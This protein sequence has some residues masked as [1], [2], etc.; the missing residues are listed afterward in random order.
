MILTALTQYYQRLLANPDVESGLA[1]VPSFGFS[2]EKIGYILVLSKDGDVVDVLNNMN[3]SGKKPLPKLTSVPQ[4]VKRTSGV[5]SNF[6][7]DKSAYVL[8]VEGNK[9]KATAKETPWL[10]AGKTFEAFKLFHMEKL[11]D[12]EDAGLLGLMHFLE[13]W[14]PEQFNQLPF[15]PEMIDANLAFK[16]DGDHQLLH[17]RVAAQFIWSK[18]LAPDEGAIESS[19][20]VTGETGPIAR[21]HP[22]IKGV[23]GGQS[24]GGSIV[25]FNADAYTSYGKHQGENAPVSE[26]AAFAYTTALN[27][28]LRRENGQCVSIGD[29][30]TVFWAVADNE[31][32]AQ[33][34]ESLFG[35][36][37]NMPTDDSQETAQIRPILD[38]VAQGRP[39]MEFA[40]DISPNTRFYILGLAPNA[41]RLSIRYWMD[42]TFGELAGHVRQHYLDLTI[43]P[44]GWREPPSIWRLLI[45]T[46]A[47]GKSENIHPQLAGELMRSILTGQAYPR[48]LL[49]QLTQRIRADGQISGIRI[50]LIKAV[51]Q[52]DYRKGL[53]QE[54][55]PMALDL[56]SKNT[57][58]LLGRLFATI[59]R[60]QESALVR[61]VNSTVADRYYGSAASVPFSVFPRLLAGSQNHLTK[62]RRDKPGF[63]VNLKKD[64]GEIIAGLEGAFPKHLSI[65]EQGRFA[66]GY[67][68]QKQ[69][70]YETKDKSVEEEITEPTV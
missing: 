56:S 6:L 67:Y 63:A 12:V 15:Q 69:S 39:L 18:L 17:D 11:A 32:S 55:V 4:P 65:E 48:M 35:W 33:A 28:L 61:E 60:I 22:S 20:L 59:E 41:A 9:D 29:A 36:M 54:E 21:L 57:A 2:E 24:S 70:Y 34:A 31:Q 37:V 40:P 66:V 52:R 51:I 47:Q 64:L 5:K 10:L 16:L 45:Q 46:A 25:S 1:R 23:Y 14:Q 58:Y 7:W 49:S 26:S 38:K 62:I 30:S 44:L 13:K 27:Y 19:C 42:T 8:G 53:I 68:H 50:S 3:T 43:K